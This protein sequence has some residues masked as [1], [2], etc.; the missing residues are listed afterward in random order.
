MSYIPVICLV[1]ETIVLWKLSSITLSACAARALH[2]NRMTATLWAIAP[3]IFEM[4]CAA[5]AIWGGW[6]VLLYFFGGPHARAQVPYLSVFTFYFFLIWSFYV[7][8][9]YI[10]VP[11]VYLLSALVSKQRP[12]QTILPRTVR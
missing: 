1:V 5:A 6:A 8:F 9:A 3:R 7:G 4:A 2:G 12:Q 10:I 11:T